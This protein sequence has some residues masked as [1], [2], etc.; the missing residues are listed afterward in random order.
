[1][2]RLCAPLYLARTF[3]R[4][5]LDE[6]D[7]AEVQLVSHLFLTA[8]EHLQDLT[9]LTDAD[10][11]DA[12]GTYIGSRAFQTA[13]LMLFASLYAYRESEQATD[14]KLLPSYNRIVAPLRK[15]LGIGVATTL[16]RSD[17]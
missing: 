6:D 10:L 14:L 2:A 1:M 16:P 4:I 13:A 7:T 15:T 9:G 11:F 3:A 17:L 8:Q 5:D 12:N